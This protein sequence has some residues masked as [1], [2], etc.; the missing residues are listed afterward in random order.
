M[1]EFYVDLQQFI[2]TL[3]LNVGRIYPFS[4][5]DEPLSDPTPEGQV[6]LDVA[7]PGRLGTLQWTPR[8][9]RPLDGDEVEVKI[10][11]AGSNFKVRWA[12][13]LYLRVLLTFTL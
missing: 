8:G 13:F 4:L 9:T 12:A 5:K 11:A 1:A 2:A 10:Y 7:K 3:V 6:V